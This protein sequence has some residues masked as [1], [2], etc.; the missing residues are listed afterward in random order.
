MPFRKPRCASPHRGSPPPR[1]HRAAL[2]SRGPDVGPA[3]TGAGDDRPASRFRRRVRAGQATSR[4]YIPLAQAGAPANAKRPGGASQRGSTRTASES[5]SG[6][7]RHGPGRAEPG[8]SPQ[9][10]ALRQVALPNRVGGRT[11]R[12]KSRADGEQDDQPDRCP[13]LFHRPN[14]ISLMTARS[15]AFAKQASALCFPGEVAQLVEHT[16]ENRGVVGSI[17]TLAIQLSPWNWEEF[18]SPLIAVFS[19]HLGSRRPIVAQSRGFLARFEAEMASR[20]RRY[21]ASQAVL[22]T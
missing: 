4:R 22:A 16:T 6:W 10:V 8:D 1:G 5:P 13:Q 3:F 15:L 17:S 2:A 18:R 9:G 7:D 19:S 20:S 11:A 12:S 14:A 21:L